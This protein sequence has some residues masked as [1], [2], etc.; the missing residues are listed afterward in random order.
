[1]NIKELG[2]RVRFDIRLRGYVFRL[3]IHDLPHVPNLK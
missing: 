1:M 3:Y 2:K